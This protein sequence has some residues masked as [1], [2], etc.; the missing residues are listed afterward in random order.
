MQIV[1]YCVNEKGVY[2]SKGEFSTDVAKMLLD[3]PKDVIGVFS[4]MDDCVAHIVKHLKVDVR[5]IGYLLN[6]QT[7]MCHLLG[8]N[9]SLQYYPGKHFMIGIGWLSKGKSR[10]EQGAQYSNASQYNVE[11][12]KVSELSGFVL[13]N[14]AKDIAEEVYKVY[15]GLGFEVDSLV[16]PVN[17]FRK[18]VFKILDL[19]R[20]CDV[21]DEAGWMALQACKG[22]WC[23]A[24][25]VGKF[26]NV[27]DWDINSSYPYQAMMLPDLRDG[28]WVHSKDIPYDAEIGYFDYTIKVKK[29]FSPIVWKSNASIVDRNFTP[30][31]EFTEQDNMRMLFCIDEFNIGDYKINDGWWWIPNDYVRYPLKTL[32]EEYYQR[33]KEA[34]GVE[35][36]VIKTILVGGFYG[37]FLQTFNDVPSVN[38]F[39]PYACEIQSGTRC[40]VYEQCMYEDVKPLHIA[41]DGVI[42]DKEFVY[43][44]GDGIGEWKLSGRGDAFIISSGVKC[45]Q[46][47]DGDG[48]FSFSYEWLMNAIR[49]S[50]CSNM[51]GLDRKNVLSVPLAWSRNRLQDIGKVIDESRYLH[52]GIENK[53]VYDVQPKS[54]MELVSGQYDSKA[55]DI[56]MLEKLQRLLGNEKYKEIVDSKV[57]RMEVK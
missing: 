31:G 20:I 6:G 38:F 3:K 14:M 4:D 21:P 39:P 35:R 43:N 9:I 26:E 44:V 2:N 13:A 57:N 30:T 52:V 48:E 24:Y 11:L 40:N 15:V 12:K 33:R 5:N 37:L 54:G 16:S 51:Y 42:T 17:A 45:V 10:F 49:G 25:K 27:Y 56:E 41:V 34:K 18:S 29:D 28:K 19:P 47:K 1:G 46:G 55:W 7:K 32:V 23:E 53:R 50:P 8:K 36:E 22:G